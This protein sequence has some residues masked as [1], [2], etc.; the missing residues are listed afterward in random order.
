MNK[1]QPS[2]HIRILRQRRVSEHKNAGGLWLAAC[3]AMVSMLSLNA[4]AQSTLT[5][6]LVAYW[7]FDGNFLDSINGFHGTQ[8]GTAPIP[9][10]DGKAG[11]GQAIKL[12]GGN[13]FVEITGGNEDDLEFPG[14]SMSISGWFKVDAFDTDWQAIISKGEGTN[15]RVARR[16]ATGAIAY[17]GGIGEGPADEP[18]VNDGLWHHFVAVTD[19]TVAAFGT[20]L[21][22]DGQ[23]YSINEGTP[24]LAENSARLMI[25]ENP[26]ARNREWEGEL[27]DFAIWDRVLTAD[28]VTAL[29]AG[30]PG[31][32]ISTLLPAPATPLIISSITQ[33]LNSFAFETTDMGGATVD[34]ASATL[35]ID[36]QPATITNVKTGA[37]TRFSFT[38]SAVWTPGSQ[39]TYSI[40]VKDNSGRTL[41][42]A[43]NFSFPNP[44]FPR[45][46]L[47]SP[48]VVSN[49]WALRWIFGA[50][51]VGDLATAISNITAVGTPDFTGAAVD[52]TNSVINFPE[53]GFLFGN[54]SPYP[55]EVIN[56]P[57]GLW[58]GEDFVLFAVGNIVIPEEG[59]YT[60]G[61]RS[62]D[63]FAF[64]I[65][66]GRAISVSGNG[67]L[68][69]VDPE[70]VVHPGTTGDSTTR[71]VYHLQ[72]GVYRVE[73]LFYERGGGDGGEFFSA[74][75]AFQNE[76]DTTT[77]KLVGDPTPSEEFLSLGVQAPGWSVVSSD[78]GGDTIT[79]WAVANADL[80][81]SAGPAQNYERMNIGDPESN[82]GV[83]PFPKNTT[84]A[85][86]NFAI[87]GTA[88]LVVPQAGT[89]LV[90]FNSDDGAYVKIT[91]RTFT[92]I[93]DNLTGL[94]VIDN[95]SV[96]CDCLT[97]DSGT[98][99]TITL[100]AGNHSI[101]A[102]MFEQGGGAYLRVWAVEQGGAQPPVLSTTSGGTYQTGRALQ[103]TSEPPGV[104]PG[105]GGDG[106]FA[107]VRLSADRASLTF[108]YS[109][110]TLESADSISGPWTP[111]AGATSPATV[112]TSGAQK[113]Y[114]VR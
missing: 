59:D 35:T 66:G 65:R 12:D 89:Y 78:P 73:W 103:L 86:D 108:E 102:G 45:A 26:E 109:G 88:T 68:D 20:A 21:Y 55:D 17:A 48:A 74:K 112:P 91:G 3:L 33:T 41:T 72:K 85:D 83:L 16:A 19:A 5:N 58:V 93:I 80:A 51:T 22:I 30:G 64:R 105:G 82:A 34:A 99:A 107:N 95:D 11:F 92:E 6:G 37:V 39:H 67:A 27:D 36:G 49:A 9:F 40:Q 94:S 84:N 7:N 111:V 8:R 32:A 101:E 13:Q 98:S 75:G 79:D 29:Y 44:W 23:I 60:F 62:D 97:G 63:G 47:K 76:G 96:I 81:A 114:R 50:G 106:G 15:Y 10:V 18:E 31:K 77:W 90:G 1:F 38:P 2:H 100:P 52:T 28:E 46:D 113:F 14:G 104:D 61:V 25:G 24:V 42:Q 71:A 70:A 56:D 110:G 57:S 4:Q 54:G 69:P 53:A 87:R 43:G